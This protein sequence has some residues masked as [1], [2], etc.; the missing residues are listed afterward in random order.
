LAFPPTRH[1]VVLAVRSEDPR[2]RA[3]ALDAVIAAYWRPVYR[4]LCGRWRAR[5]DE[6]E[7]LAQ[8]FFAVALE[9]GWLARYDSRRGRF[10]SYLLACLEGL[11]AS[12]PDP[13]TGRHYYWEIM[14]PG[15]LAG[16]IVGYAT[17]RYGQRP[18]RDL[19]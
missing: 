9:K 13:A 10:R 15:S 5:E 7:D 19:A 17:Q 12:Q 11:I 6:A 4:H 3:R 16:A 1:S 2:E 18:E 14:L 8:G